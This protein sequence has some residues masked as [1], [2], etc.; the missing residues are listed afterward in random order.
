MNKEQ[1]P[2]VSAPCASP[3]QAEPAAGS[4]RYDADILLCRLQDL[5]N[6]VEV[7]AR[8]K[9]LTDSEQG[10]VSRMAAELR[11]IYG[12]LR[13]IP[14]Q[15]SAAGS[16]PLTQRLRSRL[17]TVPKPGMKPFKPTYPMYQSMNIGAEHKPGDFAGYSS[18]NPTVGAC[19]AGH[20]PNNWMMLEMVYA[21]DPL[22]EEAARKIEEQERTLAL[23]RLSAKAPAYRCPVTHVDCINN[24]APTRCAIAKTP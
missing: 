5:L 16:V 3:V 23:A 13:V 1:P 2:L 7:A 14:A 4:D 20:D 6:W 9:C 10:R 21:V 8:F 12:E 19:A 15:K 24:C 11:S 22:C 18:Y 17:I